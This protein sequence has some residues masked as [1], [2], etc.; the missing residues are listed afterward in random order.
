L[1]AK[2]LRFTLGH[3]RR[4]RRRRRGKHFFELVMFELE[5]NKPAKKPPS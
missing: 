3:F 4:R 1:A 5:S 2:L